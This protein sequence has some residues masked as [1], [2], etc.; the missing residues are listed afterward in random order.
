VKLECE[1]GPFLLPKPQPFCRNE[2]IS[3]IELI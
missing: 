1:R 3:G 2:V